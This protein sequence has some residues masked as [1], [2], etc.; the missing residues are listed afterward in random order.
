VLLLYIFVC[1]VLSVVARVLLCEAIIM[2]ITR[3]VMSIRTLGD[4]YMAV[5]LAVQK[6]IG[7]WN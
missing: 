7:C 4:A 2:M 5:R 3:G 6:T 1:R